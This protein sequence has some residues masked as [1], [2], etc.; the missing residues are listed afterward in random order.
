MAS[1][2]LTH[3]QWREI[4]DMLT[5]DYQNLQQRIDGVLLNTG[6]GEDT[7]TLDGLSEAEHDYLQSAAGSS[8]VSGDT[9]GASEKSD[10]AEPLTP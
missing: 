4:R 9:A 5:D 3:E 8:Q 6:S 10:L 7:I 1:V 2:S